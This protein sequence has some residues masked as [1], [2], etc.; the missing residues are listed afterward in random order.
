MKAI[1]NEKYQHN[2]CYVN[3]ELISLAPY[4]LENVAFRHSYL[5]LL[6]FNIIITILNY[7]NCTFQHVVISIKE[8][9]LILFN[10][11]E[12]QKIQTQDTFD[13]EFMLK[14]FIRS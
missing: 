12:N 11:A 10:F 1:I 9:Y 8:N 3:R 6:L 5:T 7:W 4:T 14:R 13:V 2:I